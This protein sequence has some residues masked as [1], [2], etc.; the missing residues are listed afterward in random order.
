MVYEFP[1]SNTDIISSRA[2]FVGSTVPPGIIVTSHYPLVLN[3]CYTNVMVTGNNRFIPGL[4][5]ELIVG[6]VGIM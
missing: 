1:A 2:T 3:L 5:S 4:P 6:N